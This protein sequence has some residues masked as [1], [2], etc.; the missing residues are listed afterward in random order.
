MITHCCRVLA[1]GSEIF[2]LRTPNLFAGFVC[3]TIYMDLLTSISPAIVRTQLLLITGATGTLGQAFQRI[4]AIRGIATVCLDH[5]ALDITSANAIDAVLRQYQL[6]AVVN[7]AGYVNIDKAETDQEQC[8]L[9]N[10]LGPALLAQAC[11][12]RDLPF[13]TF[14]S[15]LVFDG[16]QSVAYVESDQARPLNVYGRSKLQAEHEVLAIHREALIIRT[17]A[18][19]GPWDKHNFVHRALRAAY[20]R[21]PFA[22][23]NDVL[24]SPTYV[25]DL[26]NT[27]LDLLI[28]AEQGIWHL[29]N[30]GECTWAELARLAISMAGLD[31][32]YV[33]AQ[34]MRSFGRSAARPYYSVLQ[35]QQGC[36][37]PSVESGLAHYLTKVC[38][39][40]VNEY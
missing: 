16:H 33:T 12:V 20:N 36:L 7:T 26:V 4:C 27:S 10:T 19:F 34:P 35:S 30:Q 23:A 38:V 28:D 32:T 2:A 9:T 15:A 29:T 21:V 3:L 6:W 40:P 5:K 14:S 11:A 37:L 31:S 8:Y 39:Q 18:L 25:F 13:L 24:I 22:A 17:S 1:G